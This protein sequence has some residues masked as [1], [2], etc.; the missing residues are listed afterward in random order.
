MHKNLTTTFSLNEDLNSFDNVKGFQ[1]LISEQAY[2]TFF[3]VF[4]KMKGA[5]D[6]QNNTFIPEEAVFYLQNFKGNIT[7]GFDNETIEIDTIFDVE[8]QEPT[9]VITIFVSPLKFRPFLPDNF[10]KIDDNEML[11]KGEKLQSIPFKLKKKPSIINLKLEDSPNQKEKI[12]IDIIENKNPSLIGECM[13]L[14]FSLITK[15]KFNNYNSK[16]SHDELKKE[17]FIDPEFYIREGEEIIYNLNIKNNILQNEPS[18]QPIIEIFNKQFLG[19]I[20]DKFGKTV[21]DGR[22]KSRKNNIVL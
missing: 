8:T 16:K 5:K 2:G 3:S 20:V 12:L 22:C 18:P 19:L 21:E 9:Y 4:A 13:D 6:Y 14:R 10:D 11:L 1:S 15:I 17:V 7:I